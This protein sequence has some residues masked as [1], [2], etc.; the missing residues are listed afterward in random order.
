MTDDLTAPIEPIAKRYAGPF[1]P[2]TAT[3]PVGTLT[4]SLLLDVMALVAESPGQAE[5]FERNAADVLSL[6]LG[7]SLVALALD[8]I[9]YLRTPAHQADAAATR[10]FVLN[11][12]IAAVY[13]LDVA[14][15]RK[16]NGEPGRKGIGF[17]VPAALSVA[18]L[19]L[20]AIAAKRD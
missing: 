1:N 15:R 3:L 2:L 9:E 5:T 16:A 20:L 8:I 11:G 6:G 4:A 19:S 10:E 17:I 7:G 12:A 13:L 14:A 18:G